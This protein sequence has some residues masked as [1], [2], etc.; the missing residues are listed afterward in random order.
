MRTLA[1]L[2]FALV[3]TPAA[4]QQWGGLHAAVSLEGAAASVFS[5]GSVPQQWI[6]GAR[7]NAEIGYDVELGPLVGGVRAEAAIGNISGDV[8]V[9]GAT[10]TWNLGGTV[11]VNARVGVALGPLLPYLTAGALFATGSTNSPA[12]A[13]T[14]VGVTAGAGIEAQILPPLALRAE[15]RWTARDVPEL[16]N[17][18][19]PNSNVDLNEIAVSLGVVAR[20]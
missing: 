12:P 18:L 10:V 16:Q 6:A 14:S 8:Q 7:I 3:A 2:A 20:F 4:A 11:G 5:P 15:A 1:A 17:M 13:G 19:P 9:N